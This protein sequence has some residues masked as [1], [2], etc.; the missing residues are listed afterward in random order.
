MKYARSLRPMK[1]PVSNDK[2]NVMYLPTLKNAPLVGRTKE[3]AVR[4]RSLRQKRS[5]NHVTIANLIVL[6][7]TEYLEMR[8]NKTSRI[9]AANLTFLAF[10][11]Y[12]ARQLSKEGC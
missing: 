5:A 9:E 1:V 3:A 8:L 7:L 10:S 12:S 4:R 2:Q 11:S 6:D